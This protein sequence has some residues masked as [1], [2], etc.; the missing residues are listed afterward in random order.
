MARDF[1]ADITVNPDTDSIADVITNECGAQL[2]AQ[3]RLVE[4]RLC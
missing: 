3:L 4:A 1:G 2:I